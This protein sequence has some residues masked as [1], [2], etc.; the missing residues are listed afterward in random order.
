MNPPSEV[1]G[2]DRAI[3]AGPADRRRR[4]AFSLLGVAPFIGY[5]TLL[6]GVPAASVMVEA[7][8]DNSGH[9]SLS[10]LST[11]VDS[12]QP[13][14][15][16]YVTSLELAAVSAAIA[17]AIGLVATVALVS[18]PSRTLR[19]LT[20]TAAGVLANTGG[21]PLAFAFIASI[22]NSGVV[23]SFLTHL[24]FDPYDHGFSLASFAGLVVVYL[25]FLLPLTILL[26]LP[27]V[28]ALRVEWREAASTLGADARTYWRKVGLPLLTPP[29]IA[30][31]MVL[32]MDAFAAY[33]TAEVLTTG[34]VPLVPLTIGSLLD[35]NVVANQAHLGDAL[36]FGMVVIVLAAGALY[37]VVQRRTSKWLR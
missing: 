16:D 31:L 32:F 34:T 26:L 2:R 9:L 21:V 25:Y 20:T 3:S 36:G 4:G 18:S 14:L 29:L 37:V 1:D 15:H 13:Y 8:R 27:P 23:T 24:G 7:F 35:G 28:E 19:Q 11:I 17:A 6:L 5:L 30:T 10:N 33:A 12:N 22:G